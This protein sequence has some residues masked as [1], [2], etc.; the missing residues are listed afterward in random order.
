MGLGESERGRRRGLEKE[1]KER[2]EGRKGRKEG[3]G[4]D[5]MGSK[6]REIHLKISLMDLQGGLW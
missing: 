3:G 1:R 4:N 5:K 6:R 2:A